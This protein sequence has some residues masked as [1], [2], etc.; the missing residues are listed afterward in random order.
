MLN[1]TVKK[2][3][4]PLATQLFALPGLQTVPPLLEKIGAALQSKRGGGYAATWQEVEGALNFITDT[5]PTVFDVGANL[6][7]WTSA[8]LKA[9][10]HTRKVVMFEPQT[11]CWTTLGKMCSPIVELEKA[12]VSNKSEMLTF[13]VSPNHEISSLYKSACANDESRQISVQA[14]TLDDYIDQNQIQSVDYVKIDVEG[15]ELAV[16]KGAERSIQKGIIKAFSFEIGQADVASRTFF[17]DFWQQI[18]ALH[19]QIY[20]LGHDGLP[21]LIPQYSFD[22]E[23]FGGVANYVASAH[24]PKRR[25]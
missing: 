12:A 3:A 19:L 24:R 18:T 25:R 14:V 2:Y 17:A 4:L 10:P 22:L 21:I 15:H 9:I 1:Y 20:R 11:S 8:L 16:I 6:G 5:T 13:W 7:T 23:N